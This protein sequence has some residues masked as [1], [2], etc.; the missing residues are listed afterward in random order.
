[1]RL[2][3]ARGMDLAGRLRREGFSV[4][5]AYPGGA[6]DVLGLPRKRDGVEWLRRALVRFG[7][8]GDVERRGATHDE[9]DAILCAYTA[10]EHAFGRSLVLG[11]PSEGLLVLPRPNGRRSRRR[12]PTAPGAGAPLRSARSK[13]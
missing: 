9:L 5:E 4:L 10:R 1:M 11:E 2:L 8:H 7:F 12:R 13:A 3:T 6:Q